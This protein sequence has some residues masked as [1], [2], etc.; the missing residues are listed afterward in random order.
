MQVFLEERYVSSCQEILT[1]VKA[2]ESCRNVIKAMRVCP[3]CDQLNDS[4]SVFLKKFAPQ[5][6]VR[7]K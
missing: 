5:N 1:P 2:A 4:V 7:Y 6:G 3:Q